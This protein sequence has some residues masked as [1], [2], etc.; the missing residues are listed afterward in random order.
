MNK[1]VD[2]VDTSCKSKS[3]S[4]YECSA[5]VKG[6]PYVYSFASTTLPGMLE[7]LALPGFSSLPESQKR[8]YEN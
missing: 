7:V 6:W 1:F 2:R 5:R 4:Q 8:D 3:L